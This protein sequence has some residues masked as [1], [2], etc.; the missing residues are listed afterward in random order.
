M[1]KSIHT[2]CNGQT[3]NLSLPKQIIRNQHNPMS[4]KK[5]MNDGQAFEKKLTSKQ[6]YIIIHT[7]K[8]CHMPHATT[9][10]KVVLLSICNPHP[11]KQKQVVLYD[12]LDVLGYIPSS[13]FILC[14]YTC[15]AHLFS[16]LSTSKWRLHHGGRLTLDLGH[17]VKITTMFRGS[18]M[19]GNGSM[20]VVLDLSKSLQMSMLNF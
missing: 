2:I 11:P 10:V 6:T 16:C 13:H 17:T 18:W 4:T 20:L 5:T 15:Y 3:F 19:F 12:L 1:V 7:Y 14:T 9:R 8:K